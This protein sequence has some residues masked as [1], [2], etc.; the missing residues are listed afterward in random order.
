MR[1]LPDA[2]DRA[3]LPVRLLV[4]ASWAVYSIQIALS[5]PI[6]HSY[7]LLHSLAVPIC[8]VGILGGILAVL[9]RS[10]WTWFALLAAIAFLTR[11][12]VFILAL[13]LWRDASFVEAIFQ[14]YANNWAIFTHF[15]MTFGAVPAASFAFAE[16]LMPIL[17]ASL[18]VY[19]MRP[20]TIRSRA[21]ALSAA[22]LRR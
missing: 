18:V 6:Q 17:Q 11:Y 7:V 13:A 15:A 22:E 2:A 21:D 1:R 10:I 8:L 5:F 20:L 14:V 3:G 19:L 4:L 16:F 12:I 9:R